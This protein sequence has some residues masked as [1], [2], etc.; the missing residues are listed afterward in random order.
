M[1]FEVSSIQF[2]HAE[3]SQAD[4]IDMPAVLVGA[5]MWLVLEGFTNGYLNTEASVDRLHILLHDELAT[6]IN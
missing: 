2:I 1:S 6:R 5:G 4:R 3:V